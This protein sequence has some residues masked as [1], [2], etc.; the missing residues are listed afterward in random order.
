MKAVSR[1]RA[2]LGNT[3]YVVSAEVD[4]HQVLRPLLRIGRELRSQCGVLLG[5]AP[6]GAGAGDRPERDLAVLHPDQDLGRAPDACGCRHNA[7]STGT[8]PD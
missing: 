6:R 3:P 2:E 8:A 1:T 7:D 4:E 5:V